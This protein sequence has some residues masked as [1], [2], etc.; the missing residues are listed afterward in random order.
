MAEC[1]SFRLAGGAKVC[2]WWGVCERGSG[3]GQGGR[4]VFALGRRGMLQGP[5]RGMEATN[6]A[7]RVTWRV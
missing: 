5:R 4:Q 1:M 3:Q 7:P 2:V 6:P